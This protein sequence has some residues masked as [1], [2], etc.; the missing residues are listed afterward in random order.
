MPGDTLKKLLLRLVILLAM[1]GAACS[2]T[3]ME[4]GRREGCKAAERKLAYY[5]ERE[6]RRRRFKDDIKRRLALAPISFGLGA[7]AR[8]LM[9]ATYILPAL[10][11]EGF[12]LKGDEIGAVKLKRVLS[13]SRLHGSSL[14]EI[15]NTA[16]ARTSFEVGICY[17]RNKDWVQAAAAFE[18]LNE[19]IYALYIGEENVF[20]LL[21]HCYFMLGL[22]DKSI[23][24][25]QQFLRFSLREDHR[26][27]SVSRILRTIEV[28]QKKGLWGLEKGE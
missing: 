18:S 5:T 27:E 1:M 25:Y 20:I 17:Y 10:A 19:T 3:I 28:I 13:Y 6:I 22:Y 21:G 9:H 7:I 16:M 11:P 4:V 8:Y 2:S 24:N 26:R 14:D 23:D 15:D 12:E